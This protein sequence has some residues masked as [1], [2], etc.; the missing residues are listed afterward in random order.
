MFN[1]KTCYLFL[2]KALSL[3]PLALAL[4]H[5]FSHITDITLDIIMHDVAFLTHIIQSN[6]KLGVDDSLPG[7][8]MTVGAFAIFHIL[9][10][11]KKPRKILEYR[12]PRNLLT[13]TSLPTTPP[14]LTTTTPQQP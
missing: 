3:S 8:H 1:Y 14:S 12:P 6:G 5:S 2:K 10:H 4:K 7:C 9:E 13:P 11:T